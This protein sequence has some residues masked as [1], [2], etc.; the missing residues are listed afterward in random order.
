M[1]TDLEYVVNS[2]LDPKSS[3]GVYTLPTGYLDEAGKLHSVAEVREMTGEEED[4]LASR[5]TDPVHKIN[6]IMARCVTRIGEVTDP[7]QISSAV[8]DLPV[9][10]RMFLLFAIRQVTLG[11]EYPFTTTCPEEKCGKSAVYTVLVSSIDVKNAPDPAKRLFEGILP[12][13]KKTFTYKMLTGRD[14]ASVA[15][16]NSK[17]ALSI[18]MKRRIVS[19]DGKEATLEA[20]KAIGLADRGYIRA[21][22]EKIDGGIDTSMDMVCKFCDHSFKTDLDISQAGFFFPSAVTKP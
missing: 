16:E 18:A 9:G 2:L 14:E 6:T 19:I 13:S 21:C 10:D 20:I 17:D 11:D 3:K 4:L 5:N 1:P 7:G 22:F 12:R 8:L 15:A